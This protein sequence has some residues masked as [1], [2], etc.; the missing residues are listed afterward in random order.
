MEEPP[1]EDWAESAEVHKL[2]VDMLER[3]VGDHRAAVA[4]LLSGDLLD[5][6][7]AGIVRQLRALRDGAFPSSFSRHTGVALHTV[8]YHLLGGADSRLPPPPLDAN[9]D[10][11]NGCDCG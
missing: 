6:H 8:L 1:P 5:A 3:P 4:Q 10:E 2:L 7:V 9:R 11:K